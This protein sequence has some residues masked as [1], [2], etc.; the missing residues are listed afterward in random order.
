MIKVY[1]GQLLH[2]ISHLP[3]LYPNLGRI[4]KE[5]RI[6]LENGYDVLTDKIVEVVDR[7]ENADYFLL[8]HDYFFARKE[9]GYVNNFCNSAKEA[10]KRLIIFDLSDLDYDIP[11]RRAI[12]FRTT[13]YRSQ[14]MDN[15]I[16][17]PPVVEDLGTTRGVS[18]REKGDVP[19]VGFMGWAGFNSSLDMLKYYLKLAAGSGPKKQGLYWRRKALELLSS[20]D[21]VKTNFVVRNTF[22]GHRDTIGGSPDDYRKEYV[23][24]IKNSDMTLAP[25]GDGNYSLRF[26]ETLSLARTPILI[27]TDMVLPCEDK[28]NYDDFIVRVSYAGIHHLPQIVSAWYSGLSSDEFARKQRMAREVFLKHLR[29]DMFLKQALSHESLA[30]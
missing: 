13:Q 21:L 5:G 4:K 10:G 23:E 12:I 14:K 19:T 15:E 24:N 8:P 9:A 28:I 16:I 25:K 7:I 30:Q 27:D 17:L 6:F 1:V 2:G 3:L 29:I 22:S 26:Y 20:S 18:F 11:H